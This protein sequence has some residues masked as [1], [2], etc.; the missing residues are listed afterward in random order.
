VAR[1]GSLHQHLGD[2]DVSDHGQPGRSAGSV[3]VEVTAG[4]RLQ[5]ALGTGAVRTSCHHH[6]GVDRVGEGLVVTGRAE[7]GVVEGLELAEG[8]PWLV[9]VQWH[10]EDLAPEGGPHHRLFEAFVAACADDA[11]GRG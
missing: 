2:L 8:G 7:D 6:Q 11:T 4:S 1:G 10:P 3:T 5:Q 9:A